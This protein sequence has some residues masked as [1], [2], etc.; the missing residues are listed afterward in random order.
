MTIGE[1]EVENGN[2]RKIASLHDAL[3]RSVAIDVV[4]RRI[5]ISMAPVQSESAVEK[6]AF[7]K[8]SE[9]ENFAYPRQQPWGPSDSINAAVVTAGD[10]AKLEL[11]LQSGDTIVVTARTISFEAQ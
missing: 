7:F 2:A 5:L 10:L 6:L 3:L 4:N 11:E 9:F 1:I 8:I